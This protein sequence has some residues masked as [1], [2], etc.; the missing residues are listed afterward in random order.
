VALASQHHPRRDRSP[1]R[2]RCRCPPRERNGQSLLVT[3]L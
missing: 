1:A 3:W 2:E